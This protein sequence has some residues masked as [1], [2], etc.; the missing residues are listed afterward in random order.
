MIYADFECPRCGLAWERTKNAGFRLGLRHFPVSSAHKSARPAAAA[1]EAAANQGKF[2]EM[3]ELLFADQGRL[4][5]PHLWSRAEQLEL[6]L[7]QF[8][9]D[10]SSQ[11]VADRITTQFKAAIRAGV[12][13]TPSF[14]VNGVVWPGV[15]SVDG[16]HNWLSA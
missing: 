10:L 16:V 1:A 3:V 6:D 9:S 13:T 14:L 15:P 4:D 8:D 7:D 5:A 2:W 12:A 11:V